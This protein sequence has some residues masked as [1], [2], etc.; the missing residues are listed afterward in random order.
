MSIEIRSFMVEGDEWWRVDTP[1]GEMLLAGDEKALHH[2]LLPN[3][4]AGKSETL[5]DAK[6]GRPGAV[7]EAELQL[8]AYFAGSL[9]RFDLPLEPI[10]TPFQRAVWSAL[11]GIPYG[12][13][14][15]YGRLAE[16]V[17][18]PTAYR[19]VGAANGRNPLPVVLPCHRVIGSNGKLVGFGGG[20]ELKEDLL[21]H[22]RRVLEGP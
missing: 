11:A 13:T 3:A 18:K 19:A 4:A 22:E 9:R 16:Q 12:R 2:V 14:V 8:K 1:F 7:A 17:G 20:L 15:S 21:E 5:D 10:G 6:E